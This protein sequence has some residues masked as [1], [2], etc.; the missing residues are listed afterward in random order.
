MVSAKSTAPGLDRQLMR[1][2]AGHKQDA[3]A[4][5]GKATRRHDPSV[6]PLYPFISFSSVW[7]S[8]SPPS[9][10][11]SAFLFFV[12]VCHRVPSNSFRELFVYLKDSPP[13][14][15]P[16]EEEVADPTHPVQP[17][18]AAFWRRHGRPRC[19]ALLGQCV[20]D[21]F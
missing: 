16:E 9:L 15:W 18:G 3:C 1:F 12:C 20:F 6:N 11:R 14:G 4:S 7:L 19:P 17:I 5:P 21:Q 8:L 13:I 2:R 10:L